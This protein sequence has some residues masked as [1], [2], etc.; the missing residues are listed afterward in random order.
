M[1]ITSKGNADQD[2]KNKLWGYAHAEVPLYLLVDRF[3]EE[4]PS[5]GLFS[6]PANGVYQETH[7]VPFGEKITL[8]APFEMVLNTDEF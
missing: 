6:K 3:A 1:E 4:G 8:P 7:R 2:R 5:V